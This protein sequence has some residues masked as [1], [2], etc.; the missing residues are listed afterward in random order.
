MKALRVN[1][2]LITLIITTC[3]QVM[4]EERQEEGK[5]SEETIS[6]SSDER[7]AESSEADF[8]FFG[9][10]NTSDPFVLQMYFF[11]V[12]NSLINFSR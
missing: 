11:E 8:G 12:I 6:S 1:I 4:S 9:R 2:L 10:E 5:K 7:E 3:D